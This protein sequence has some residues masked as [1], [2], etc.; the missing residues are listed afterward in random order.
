MQLK[1]VISTLNLEETKWSSVQDMFIELQQ[2]YTD[3]YHVSFMLSPVHRVK[4]KMPS[5]R[6]HK[7]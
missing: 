4:T 7:Y 2:Y 1:N 5:D 6:K 3:P